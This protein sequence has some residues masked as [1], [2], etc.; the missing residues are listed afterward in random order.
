MKRLTVDEVHASQV[1]QLGLDPTALDLESVEAIA[2]SLRRVARFQCPCGAATLVRSVVKPL[3]GLVN[4]IDETKAVI[5]KTLEAMIAGGDLLEYPAVETET[6]IPGPALLYPAPP[7]FVARES[8]TVILLGIGSDQSSPLPDDLATRVEYAN[9]LRRL[10]PHPGENLRSELRE[11]GWIQLSPGRW[12]SGPRKESANQHLSR[13]DR[14]LD[15]SGRSGDVPGLSLLDPARP[16]RFY[17]GRWVSVTSQSGR[18]MARR[19]QAYGADLWCYIELSNGNPKRLLDLPIDQN[20]WR[21][22]DEAWRLQMAIDAHRETPQGFR[23]IQGPKG[24]RVVQFFSPVP[25]W[26]QRRWDAVAEPV[27]AFGCLFAYRMLE[28]EVAEELRF[29]REELWLDQLD[30]RPK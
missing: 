30:E 22:C 1:S 29:A 23:V 20:Q 8:G 6:E 15:T 5:E 2:A 11:R 25:M 24:T 12:L 27:P 10:I 14:L 9:H 3:R 7:S 18:F 28:S 17:P 16:V 21:G 4:D 13:V 19:S 26:A